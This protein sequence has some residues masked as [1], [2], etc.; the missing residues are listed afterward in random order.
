V[1]AV[2]GIELQLRAASPTG[3]EVAVARS[4]IQH[5]APGQTAFQFYRHRL[6]EQTLLLRPL[7]VVTDNG[8]R[9]ARTLLE[10]AGERIDPSLVPENP[11]FQNLALHQVAQ[12][13]RGVSRIQQGMLAQV[14]P[15]VQGVDPFHVLA[16]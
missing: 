9:H 10:P 14:E 16:R 4:Q 5:L 7:K 2:D 1:L 6:S 12:E 11:E 8:S 3:L 13:G 15:P